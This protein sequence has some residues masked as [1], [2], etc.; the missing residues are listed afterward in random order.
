MRLTTCKHPE[1]RH[2]AKGLC[3][4]C[5]NCSKQHCWRKQNPERALAVYVSRQYGISL[6]QYRDML[7]VQGGKC[8]ICSTEAPQELAGTYQSRRLSV[9]HCHKTGYVRG[10]LCT[11]C[12]TVL[13]L[14]EENPLILQKI[15]DYIATYNIQS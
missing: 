11:K 3:K 4:T 8:A 14:I 15:S 12:N 1:R 13:G 10:L 2:Y 5:Y 6:Q 7:R 9:D